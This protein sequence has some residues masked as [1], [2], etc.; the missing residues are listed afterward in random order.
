MFIFVDTKGSSQK[1]KTAHKLKAQ[2][3]KIVSSFKGPT[4]T[5]NLVR[6]FSG[7]RDGVWEVAVAR[8]GQPL[9]GTAATGWYLI[10]YILYYFHSIFYLIINPFHSRFLFLMLSH[11]E[12][13]YSKKVSLYNI[14]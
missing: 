4:V 6:E 3:S 1:L 12:I 14:E 11:W 7:H 13:T 10:T 8:P 2:T 9:I 5:C